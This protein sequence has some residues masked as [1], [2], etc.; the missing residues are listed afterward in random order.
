MLRNNYWILLVFMVSL[1]GCTASEPDPVTGSPRFFNQLGQVFEPEEEPAKRLSINVDAVGA[2]N[3]L[4]RVDVSDTTKAAEL[5][6]QLLVERGIIFPET[7][8]SQ[9]AAQQT[10]LFHGDNSPLSFECQLD[11]GS[12]ADSGGYLVIAT[13]RY[14]DGTDFISETTQIYFAALPNDDK[15]LVRNED[16]LHAKLG[17][18]GFVDG[19][20]SL[21][22]AIAQ[23]QPENNS[24]WH[25]LIQVSG[26]SN[27]YTP[28]VKVDTRQHVMF[29]ATHQCGSYTGATVYPMNH[30]AMRIIRVPLWIAPD[31]PIG[32]DSSLRITPQQH[33]NMVEYVPLYLTKLADNDIRIEMRDVDADESIVIAPFIQETCAS[34]DVSAIPLSTSSANTAQLTTTNTG[35]GG[36]VNA[37]GGTTPLRPVSGLSGDL[38][39]VFY[40]SQGSF[41]W[42]FAAEVTRLNPHLVADGNVFYPSKQYQLP[43]LASNGN[44]IW[45]G[46][47]MTGLSSHRWDVYEAYVQP[48]V[49]EHFQAEVLRL[50]PHLVADNNIFYPEKNYV[51]PVLNP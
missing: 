37:L 27:N 3:C 47:I 42:Y 21:K 45:Q 30:Q 35:G 6:V 44:L 13:A 20:H 18:T 19:Q 43:G 48:A 50:N 38:W 32:A 26:V 39:Q 46:G 49:W 40:H 24:I 1:I 16:E 31:M 2:E 12:I 34:S 8:S 29:D 33:H 7:G 4:I 14:L 23:P 51:L 41:F 36:I 10:T 17:I 22:Y 5:E 25:L 9:S 11:L 28:R 15:H